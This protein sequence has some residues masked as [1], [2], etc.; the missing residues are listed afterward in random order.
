MGVVGAAAPAA[1]AVCLALLYALRNG[2]ANTRSVWICSRNDVFANLAVLAVALGVF[3]TGTGWPDMIVAAV[4]AV[5]ATQGSVTIV[6]QAMSELHEDRRPSPV[7][8][9]R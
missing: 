9:L 5:L 2:D 4:M 8:V 7:P 6:R 1:N 3:G